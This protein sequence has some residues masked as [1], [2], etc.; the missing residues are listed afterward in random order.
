MSFVE[1]AGIQILRPS[2]EIE[3]SFHHEAR[4]HLLARF[5]PGEYRGAE[6]AN[7]VIQHLFAFYEQRLPSLVRAISDRDTVEF[8]LWQYDESARLLHGT[9][10]RDEQAR[11]EWLRIGPLFRRAIKYLVELLC[12]ESCRERRGA[13]SASQALLALEGALVCAESLFELAE[14]SDRVYLIF[15]DECVVTVSDGNGQHCRIS[16]EGA[17]ADDVHRFAKRV[18]RD[19]SSRAR[20]IDRLESDY[21][22]DMHAPYLDS[23]FQDSF[24]MGYREFIDA[25]GA[26]IN[27]PQP[28]PDGLSSLFVN[29]DEVVRQLGQSGRPARAIERALGGFTISADNLLKEPRQPWDPKQEY[30]AFRR[31]FFV[32]PHP[33]GEHLAFSRSMAQEGLIQLLT[34]VPYKRLPP[35]WR[36]N[37][38]AKA[39]ERL[40]NAA[41]GR[42][43]EVVQKQLATLGFG[44][45]RLSDCVGHSPHP[46]QIPSCVGGIDFLGY[47]P[48]Q[49]LLVLIEAKRVKPGIEARYWR[50]DVDEFAVRSDSY[51]RRFRT[52]IEW[53]KQNRVAVSSVLG[54]GRACRLGVA[55]LTLYPTMAQAFI[56]DFPCVSLA[57]FMLD[58]AEKSG[59]PYPTE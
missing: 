35:E 12:V 14:Q 18:A 38:T 50:D 6:Q 23:A 42:F 19:R 47:Q 3:V 31:G 9:G 58:Y 54:C 10:I 4:T 33:T 45:Q 13:R 22:P 34:G 37:A 52:K 46:F 24:D 59:W 15:P 16:V 27:G 41:G 32:F 36:T 8:L 43:E 55:M 20:F 53:V 49:K 5:P 51:A 39:L 11:E 40:S 25:I 7:A 48:E 26:V 28:A 30:R 2:R 29:R 21:H 1:F 56:P 17:H 57:E 44:G